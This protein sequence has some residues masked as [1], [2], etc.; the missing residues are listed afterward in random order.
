M[1]S[2]T[3]SRRKFLGAAATAAAFAVVPFNSF[4][5]GTQTRKPNSKVNGVQLGLTTYC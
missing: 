1:K 5:I 3:I 2:S 4:A